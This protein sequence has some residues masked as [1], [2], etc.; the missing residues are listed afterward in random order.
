M[1]LKQNAQLQLDTKVN[2]CLKEPANLKLKILE[3][4]SVPGGTNSGCETI[5][6]I[7]QAEREVCLWNEVDDVR[8][9]EPAELSSEFRNFV[10][11]RIKESEDI[12]LENFSINLKCPERY[13][14]IFKNQ[15][16]AIVKRVGGK[17]EQLTSPF[18]YN[19][20]I[21]DNRVGNEKKIMMRIK[22]TVTEETSPSPYGSEVPNDTSIS[23]KA[24]SAKRKT[25]GIKRRL[26]LASK[27][28]SDTSAKNLKLN[29][30]N[31]VNG[32]LDAAGN[33]C[34]VV[35][36]RFTLSI[37]PRMLF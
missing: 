21:I 20:E 31:A 36:V 29:H 26:S 33:P 37:L 22:K 24:A 9:F 17:S 8:Y 16:G 12:Y 7:L 5:E 34:S 11:K 6:T 32:M 30:A 2:G 1:R 13:D 23:N 4:E 25:L 28:K 10:A 35:P 18:K 15:L 19:S 27:G 3:M 14:Y